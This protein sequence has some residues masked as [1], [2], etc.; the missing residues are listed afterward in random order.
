VALGGRQIIQTHKTAEKKV[1]LKK[2]K[3]QNEMYEMGKRPKCV[4]SYLVKGDE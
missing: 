3:E 2:K 1:S 4:D